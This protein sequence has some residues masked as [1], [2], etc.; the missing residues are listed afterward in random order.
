MQSE[1]PGGHRRFL[2]LLLIGRKTCSPLAAGVLGGKRVH[3][4]GNVGGANLAGQSGGNLNLRVPP[5]FQ[6]AGSRAAN[7]CSA[8]PPRTAAAGT[9]MGATTDAGWPQ[10]APTQRASRFRKQFQA[11]GQRPARKR[12][13]CPRQQVR[14]GPWKLRPIL[15]QPRLRGYVPGSRGVPG[16]ESGFV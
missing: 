15:F 5:E 4:M 1:R 6:A 14:T 3:P 16:G 9:A 7:S 10:A 11:R 13:Q 2:D 8:Q 12:I